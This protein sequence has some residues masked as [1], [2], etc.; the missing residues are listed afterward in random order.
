M[1]KRRLKD[2]I[3]LY[4]A[5][6]DS[7]YPKPIQQLVEEIM[8]QERQVQLEERKGIM[9]GRG[10]KNNQVSKSDR[11]LLFDQL[12]LELK[13]REEKA[14]RRSRDGMEGGYNFFKACAAVKVT[15]QQAPQPQEQE[16]SDA[17][18]SAMTT[19]SL[20]QD[21]SSTTVTTVTHSNHSNS[22]IESSSDASSFSMMIPSLTTT[23]KAA[24]VAAGTRPDAAIDVDA[25][26]PMGPSSVSF[27]TTT[28]TSRPASSSRK[29][30]AKQARLPLTSTNTNTTVPS[31]SNTRMTCTTTSSSSSNKRSI[32]GEWKCPACTFENLKRKHTTATCEMCETPRPTASP[33][34]F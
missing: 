12:L 33:S 6:C 1:L 16:V 19:P 7:L 14:P 2:Y 25:M 22:S 34:M 13:E 3:I 4:N 21:A 11:A 27:M 30:K 15:A 17:K 28:P 10:S 29:R 26:V 8:E 18:P 23:G 20:G 5:N 24:T 9:S 32:S 31:A